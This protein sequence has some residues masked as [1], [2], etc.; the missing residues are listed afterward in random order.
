MPVTVERDERYGPELVESLGKA[1]NELEQTL[2][3][4]Y[5]EPLDEDAA[6]D[7]ETYAGELINPIERARSRR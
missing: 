5:A 4:P 3:R 2:S 6:E 1:T 7:L